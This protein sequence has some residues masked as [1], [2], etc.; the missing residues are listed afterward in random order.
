MNSFV[1]WASIFLGSY[2]LWLILLTVKSMRTTPSELNEFFLAGKNVSFIPSV[3]TFW[4]TYFSAAALIGGAGY[5]YIN[6]IGNLY[7]ASLGYCILAVIT[8]T[9]G[10]KL[11]HLSRE[12]PEIRSPIQLYLKHF[13]S[14]A[15]EVLFVA[16][17]LLCLVPYMA[18]QI[19]GFAWL[20]E[21]A[22]GLPY[23][24]TAAG[25]LVI[26]FLYSESGGLKNIVRTDVVQSTMTIVGCIGVVIAFL[27][28]YWSMDFGQ[29]LKDVDAVV[30]P[31]LLSIPGP[32]GFYSPL[33]IVSLALL[34]SLGAIPMAHNA[35]RYMI[36]HDPCTLK[37]LMWMFPV[38][39][40]FVTFVAAVLGM[41]GAVH[42]PGLESGDQVIGKVTAAVPPMIGA[43]ATV[44][45]IA[46]TMST[47]D[48]ILLSVGFIVSEQ[49]Y[50]EKPQ[51]SA[52]T[53]L[54]LNRWC[55]LTVAI[56]AFIASIR[57]ELVTELAFNAFGGMLQL[58]PAMIAGI[59]RIHIGKTT[60]FASA[61]GGL[62]IV[63]LGNTPLYSKLMPI[64]M[65]HYMC[66]FLVA[67]TVV[68]VGRAFFTKPRQN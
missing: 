13:N 15:L 55:T 50:R 62:A 29:F 68:V 8:G 22:L 24:Y 31:S 7:F 51:T 28:I 11:W 16:V 63:V 38:M 57:P 12:H 9:V 6:G 46:A 53:V 65:P 34:I 54:R 33:I 47:A 59:Y 67:L 60:A 32:K 41:G 45:I 19:T 39:G 2:L 23:I 1:L 35:Q 17:S 43:L 36:V 5:Y 52:K 4:A 10:R 27:W 18:A 44:G 25:A 37:T 40:V 56:F 64:L 49:W 66:G 61:L 21:S 26:V 42:F 14:P 30:K 20:I 3:L 58:A 48:S